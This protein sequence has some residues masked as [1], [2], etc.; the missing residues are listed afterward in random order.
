MSEVGKPDDTVGV[1]IDCDIIDGLAIVILE[2]RTGVDIP[3]TDVG[4]TAVG[5]VF[6][7]GRTTGVDFTLVGRMA[8]VDFAV[9]VGLTVLGGLLMRAF[10]T[11]CGPLGGCQ[12][13]RLDPAKVYGEK[14]QLAEY[15]NGTASEHSVARSATYRKRS[16]LESSIVVISLR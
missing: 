11:R 4:T 15:C 1:E 16:C 12:C 14:N 13:E 10:F 9:V 7:V 8:R 5:P 2:L 3:T 6:V